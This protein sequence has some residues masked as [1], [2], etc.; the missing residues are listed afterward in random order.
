MK[1]T[2]TEELKQ[3]IIGVHQ[4]QGREWID[5]FAELVRYCENK[6][7]IR[8]LTPYAPSYH[9]VTP[10]V[11]PNGT[12]AVLKLG[13]PGNEMRSEIETLLTYKGEGAVRLLD[14]DHVRGILLLER[15]KPGRTLHSIPDDEEAVRIA[16]SVM[17]KIA[18]PAPSQAIFPSTSDWAN[19]LNKLRQRYDGGTGPFPE[20][21][22]EKAERLYAM[23]NGTVQNKLLLHGDLHHGNIL[24]AEREP[25]L[26]ID[27]KG[28]IGEAEYGVIQFLLNNL[29]GKND[30]EII[31]RRINQFE[32]EL[33]LNKSRIIAWTFCHAVLSAW[34]HLEGSSPGFD[35][36]LRTAIDIHDLLS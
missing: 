34:W 2:L 28:L 10:V 18:R 32:K 3:T 11:F 4:E 1:P 6:W 7:E 31:E 5:N 26:A 20:W 22:V 33:Q 9:F 19:G 29:P 21:I 30:G 12:E 15:L 27:P 25:W 23:L 35:N 17:R 16:A 24:S 8:F 14:S 36:A 13:V